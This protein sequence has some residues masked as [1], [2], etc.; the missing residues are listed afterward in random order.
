MT[1]SSVVFGKV[2]IEQTLWS[3]LNV[4]VA[5]GV[6]SKPVGQTEVATEGALREDIVIVV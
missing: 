4:E 5:E 3:P 6:P 1:G 2:A